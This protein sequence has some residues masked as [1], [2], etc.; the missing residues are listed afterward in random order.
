MTEAVTD[1]IVARSRDAEKLS[2]MVGWSVGL[3]VVLV[4]IALVVP[5]AAPPPPRTVMTISLGGVVGPKAGGLTQAGGRAVQ[6]PPPTEPVRR[7]ETPPAPKPPPMTIPQPQARPRPP[8]PKPE[9]AP[10]E[11]TGRTPSTGEQPREGS[12]RVETG[13]RGQ[14]FGLSTGGGG[15]GGVRVDAD[16]C[17]PE[18]LVDMVRRIRENWQDKQGV[19]GS[20][21]MR[22]TIRRDGT[23]DE[24]QV[25]RPSGFFVLDEAS[26]RALQRTQRLP[27][28]P[29]GYPASELPV[30]LRFDYQR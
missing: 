20:T 6:A 16:F 4:A 2:A 26:R 17:C 27:P 1:V 13:A 10:P 30:H 8:Q 28:L 21:G 15:L 5:K 22:F 23:L 29:A 18:Y 25:E 7:A 9:Q 3:H 12:T 11:A 19:V 24:I 14:G